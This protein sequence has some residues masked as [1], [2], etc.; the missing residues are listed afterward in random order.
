MV[1]DHYSQALTQFRSVLLTTLEPIEKTATLPR[2]WIDWFETDYQSLSQLQLQNEQLKTEN[3]LLKAQLQQLSKLKLDVARLNRLLGTASQMNDAQVQIASVSFYSQSPYTHF[4]KL[5]KGQL[6]Q[7]QPN[8]IVIDAQGLVGQITATTALSS[9]VQ[10]ITDP[11]IQVPVRVQRNGQRGILGGMG[12]EPLS[13]LFVPDGSDIK[14]G[15]LLETSGLGHVYPEGYPV[16]RVTDIA[17]IQG[18]PYLE[19]KAQPVAQLS[20]TQKVLILTHPQSVPHQDNIE[21]SDGDQ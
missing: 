16:A 6:D 13:L 1:A 21:A 20:R 19:I 9:R 12:H 18:R 15:D 4:F 10:L 8:Q 14:T 7:V 11:D 3:L 17:P 5:N 2:Q